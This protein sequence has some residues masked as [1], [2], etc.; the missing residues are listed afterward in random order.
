MVVLSLEL[1]HV[2]GFNDFKMNFS[3]PRKLNTNIIENEHLNEFTSFRY[4]KLNVIFGANATGK[5]SLIKTIWY[6]AVFLNQKNPE[7][8]RKMIN[9]NYSES[10][11]NFDFVDSN[12]FY[13]VK[14]KTNNVHDDAEIVMAFKSKSLNKNDSYEKLKIVFDSYEYEFKNCIDVLQ[15]ITLSGGWNAILPATEGEFNSINFIQTTSKDEE[16]DYV[17]ILYSVLSTLD[18]SISNI[19]PSKD[20]N[21]AYVI[22][23]EAGKIIVQQGNKLSGIPLLSSG[24]KYGINIANMLY[25]IKYH[26]NGIY[27]IDEQFSY[28][29]SDVE[30]A[31]LSTMVSLL[32]PNEQLFFTTHNAEILNLSFPFH[33]YY[34]IRKERNKSGSQ[35]TI[36]CASDFENRNNVSVKNIFDNDVFNTSPNIEK[37][38]KVGE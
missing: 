6:L 34:F 7:Y 20:S 17:N 16:S 37:I 14:I 25:S 2:F 3:Y 1:N 10:T 26:L 12:K 28:L 35:Y 24:T 21:D 38:Y 30:A 9:F 15:T 19:Y 27:L 23:H 33:S 32:G 5:T 18:P 11:I 8:I 31:I 22:E 4:K 36:N 29:N 13:R